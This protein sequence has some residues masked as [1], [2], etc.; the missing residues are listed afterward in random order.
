MIPHPA[1]SGAPAEAAYVYLLQSQADGTHDVE[2]H[3]S[4]AAA[5]V[6]ER[7]L[8]RSPKKLAMCKKRMLNRAAIGRPRQ[9][10]G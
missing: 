1:A 7:T 5:K 8:K 2:A 4:M 6:Y 10:V 3:P 9:G